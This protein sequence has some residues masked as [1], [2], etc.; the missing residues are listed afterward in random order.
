MLAH[1][2]SILFIHVSNHRCYIPSLTGTRLA[3]PLV[4]INGLLLRLR[5]TEGAQPG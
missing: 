4:E 1:I 3:L 5:K 2:L